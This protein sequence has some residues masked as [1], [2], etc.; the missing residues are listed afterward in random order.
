MTY[1]D[2]PL[3]NACLNGTSTV[4]L[5]LGWSVFSGVLGSVLPVWAVML[6]TCA[7]LG[8]LVQGSL[9]LVRKRLPMRWIVLLGLLRFLIVLVFAA[10]L[11]QPIVAFR[12]TVPEGPPVFVLL[13]ASQSMGL[14]DSAAPAGRLAE[15]AVSYQQALRL[16][17]DRPEAHNNLG[18]V[19]L[20]QNRLS[21]AAAQFSLA[22]ANLVAAFVL[23]P[24]HAER[25]A[26]H[27][28]E[29]P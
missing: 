23:L 9:V 8:L 4:L 3:V 19:Y 7:L 24:E 15:A 10:C 11:L 17:P 29:Q 1:T 5:L 2:L 18:L 6:I 26:I 20:A 28:E 14:K 12:R 22:L 16:Q 21:E 13:D 27:L 25:H